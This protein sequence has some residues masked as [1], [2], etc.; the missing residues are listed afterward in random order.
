MNGRAVGN[1]YAR[2]CHDDKHVALDA[3]LASHAMLARLLGLA[4]RANA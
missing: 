2:A 3:P 4:A 1:M